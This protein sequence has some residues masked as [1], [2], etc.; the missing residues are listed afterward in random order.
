MMAP[1]EAL[2]EVEGRETSALFVGDERLSGAM[3]Y[4][5]LRLN[6]VK[7]WFGWK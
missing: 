1:F 7:V 4:S 3:L 2:L 6:G 5:E